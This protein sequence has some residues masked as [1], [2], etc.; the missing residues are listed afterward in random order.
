MSRIMD[1]SGWVVDRFGSTDRGTLLD[2]ETYGSD[3]LRKDKY[4]LERKLSSLEDRLEEHQTRYEHFL[5]K[6][7]E[8]DEMKQQQLAQKARFEKKKYAVAKKQF[9]QVSIKLGTVISI[10]GMREITSMQDQQDYHIDEHF[11][12]DLDTTEL[13]QQLIDQM[14]AFGLNIE[15]MQAVQEALDVEV[16]DE[17]LDIDATEE[18]TLMDELKAGEISRDQIRL[19]DDATT[20]DEATTDESDIDI[21]DARESDLESQDED[22][23]ALESEVDV[24]MDVDIDPDLEDEKIDLDSL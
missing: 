6:G 20:T 24:D 9:R 14:S 13:Q 19:D 4:K 10:E 23:E 11:D 8:A 21:D 12:A 5:H 7:A 3:A 2:E 1:I 18:E 15:D 22:L 16:L 17:Q